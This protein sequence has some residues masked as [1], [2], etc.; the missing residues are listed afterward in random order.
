M[1]RSLRPPISECTV[2]RGLVGEAEPCRS[3]PTGPPIAGGAAGPNRPR[4]G[5]SPASTSRT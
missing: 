1:R 2:A 4:N 3:S 5:G